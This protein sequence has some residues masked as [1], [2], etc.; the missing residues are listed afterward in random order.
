VGVRTD[1][2]IMRM[3]RQLAEEMKY[4]RFNIATDALIAAIAGLNDHQREILGRDWQNTMK[5]E[6][7]KMTPMPKKRPKQ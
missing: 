6:M 5:K 4:H 2:A 7:K 1:G 3:S